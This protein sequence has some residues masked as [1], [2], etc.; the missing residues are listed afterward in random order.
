MDHNTEGNPWYAQK[1]PEDDVIIS[2]RVRLCRNLADFPFPGKF[3]SDDNQRVKNLIFDAFS[4]PSL[5]NQFHMIDFDEI[6]PLGLMVLKER[7]VVNKRCE[8]IIMSNDGFSSCTVNSS[9]HLK[10]SSFAAGL[11]LDK[12]VNTAC[13]IDDAL[14]NKL[15]FAASFQFGYLSSDF[16]NSGS[17]MKITVRIHIP[18][19]VLSR[20]FDIVT[21]ECT[22]NNF[23]IKQLINTK[24]PD[25]ITSIFE[26][27]TTSSSV[28]S[29]T[30]N[31]FS[32]ITEMMSF[33]NFIVK[34][35]RKIR[36]EFADNEGTTI[37]NLVRRNWAK[38]MYSTLIEEEEAVDFVSA[39][40]FGLHTGIIEG[41]SDNQLD[42]LIFATKDGHLEYLRQ[43]YDFTFEKDLAGNPSA[44][45]QRLRA[46]VV[47][48][49]FEKITFKS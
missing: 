29:K 8:A 7:G 28:A 24:N 19:I 15:Q 36:A 10:I 6:K 35:E 25:F 9:D 11:D 20:Q 47:Q 46:V 17:G 30:N 4:E 27:S 18:A 44:Q 26:V 37:L 13:Q 32:L 45:L 33:C 42:D 5:E 43:N 38:A 14:Q 41:I 23:Q 3:S 31:E 34:T 48:E 2:T 21:K 1:G 40:K 49:A 39:M 12:A 22:N 16:K